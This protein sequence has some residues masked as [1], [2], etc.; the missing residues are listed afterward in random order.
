MNIEEF[1][2]KYHSL[3]IQPHQKRWIDFLEHIKHRGILLAP[4]GHGKTTTINLLWLSWVIVNN[5]D[6]RILLI[7][8]S[9]D[10]AESFSRAV[11]NVMENPE[12]Q[13]EFGFE[14]GT[15]WRSNSWRLEQSPQSKPTLECK[16]ALGR[17]TGWRGDMVIF[18]D[19]LEFSTATEGSLTKLYEWIK[20][21]VIPAINP[22]RLDKVVVVGTRKGMDDWYGQL[23]LNP[24]YESLVDTAFLDEAE[25]QCL[26]PYLYDEHG[27]I[28][29]PWWNRE[30]LLMRKDEIGALKFAQEYMNRPSPNEGLELDVNW[31]QY[32]ENLPD[33]TLHRYIGIDPSGG[34]S[35]TEASYFAMCCVAHDPY[36]DNIYVLD[37]HRS[38][39]SK[40]QQVEH[41]MEWMVRYVP[42]AAYIENVFEY[43][44]VFDA[45]VRGHFP[46]VKEKDY[47]H[48][49]LK[50]V[51][52]KSKE[53]RIREVLAPAFEMR[54]IFLRPPT[55][56]PMT[57][58]FLD[59]EYRAFPMG[60]KDLL[61]AM[62]LAVHSLVKIGWI[63]RIPWYGVG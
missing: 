40:R 6:L 54:R 56:D 29:V 30:K 52:E 39:C 58:T 44:H 26:A 62:V 36:T 37:M 13:M 19:L 32:Y 34:S 33:A 28:I 22:H 55:L 50:G 46:N 45:L 10:M 27:Q 12:L 25:T 51:T 11:R 23:L 49:R 47:I 8:H 7:S 2:I 16:G 60:D 20:Q 53:G 42:E 5:P 14:T 15:P 35:L 9:K 18:D 61:D 41:A 31:L 17:M 21:D 63:D 4:R 59:Y 1:A 3:T 48:T 24:A 38:K 57:K 43:T